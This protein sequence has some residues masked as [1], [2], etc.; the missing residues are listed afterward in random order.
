MAAGGCM[1]GRALM[2]FSYRPPATLPSSWLTNFTRPASSMKM[3][4]N[5]MSL[6]GWAR[7]QSGA[8][9]NWRQAGGD[10]GKHALQVQ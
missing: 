8:E 4:S 6:Q 2:R 9:V 7:A 10:G 3:F 5:L 1:Q